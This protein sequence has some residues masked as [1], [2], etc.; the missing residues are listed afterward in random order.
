MGIIP[1]AKSVELCRRPDRVDGQYLVAI[2][3]VEF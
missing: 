1:I 2:N 3:I